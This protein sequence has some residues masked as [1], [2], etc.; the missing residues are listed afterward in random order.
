MAL[1]V[2]LVFIFALTEDLPFLPLLVVMITTPFAAR[3]PYSEVVAASFRIEILSTSSILILERA[4]EKG[5]PSTTYRGSFDALIDPNPRIRIEG[6]E[7]GWPFAVT[8]ATPGAEPI[9]AEATFVSVLFWISFAEIF[10]ALP[11]KFSLFA[12]P[13]ATTTT[14]SSDL[15]SFTITTLRLVWLPTATSLLPRSTA[16]NTS[17]FVPAGTLMLNS[18]FS[19]VELPLVPF[20]MVTETLE[21]G[22]P[23]SSNTFPVILLSCEI[24]CDTKKNNARIRAD[25]TFM[26]VNF[27]F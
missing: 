5:T 3:D 6:A 7:P 24:L 19:F 1:D 4:A 14:F 15:A 25:R 23:V 20:L 26:S 18:P 2:I 17:D 12:V 9:S 11:V 22:L 16:V 10:A 8:A 21:R 27:K 13:Y